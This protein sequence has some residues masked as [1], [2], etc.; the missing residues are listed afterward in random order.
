MRE[1]LFS[2]RE[3][4]NFTVQADYSPAAYCEG[5]GSFS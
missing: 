1:K 5:R 2:I 4:G 3:G